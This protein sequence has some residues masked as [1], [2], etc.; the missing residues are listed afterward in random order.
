MSLRL[1]MQTRRGKGNALH[2]GVLAATGDIVVLID[3]DG[4]TDPQEIGR[5]VETLLTGADF[6][7]GSRFLRDA[8]TMD[9]PIYRQIGNGALVL[10]TNILFRTHYTD[11]TY[12]YNAFWKRHATVPA[13]EIDG[14]ANEIITN[15]RVARH[16]L[17]V[18][19]VPSFEH[20][21]LAGEAKLQGVFRVG[22]TILR[23]I[24][25]ERLRPYRPATGTGELVDTRNVV[26]I[27]AG[28]EQ[29][30]GDTEAESARAVPA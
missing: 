10:L 12:G 25:A 11:I 18:V 15:I 8:G 30:A 21:R 17:R 6:A 2:S 27:N 1:V 20:C 22:W 4:S 5:F 29:V 28:G 3:A 23:A 16:G 13:W 26:T 9:M 14:W 24:L 7:K 19:E